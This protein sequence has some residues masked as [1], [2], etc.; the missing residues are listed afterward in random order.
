MKRI[1]VT[2]T[3]FLVLAFAGALLCGSA[4]A[5]EKKVV[6]RKVI[7]AEPAD[8]EPGNP[9]AENV[10]AK[11]KALVIEAIEPG[12]EAMRHRQVSWLGVST[13]ETTDALTSQLGLSPGEGLVVSY[14][15]EDSPAAKAGLKQND[16]LVQF[17]DQSLVHPAQLKKLVQMRKEGESVDITY[18]RAGKKDSVSVTLGKHAAEPDSFPELRVLQGNMRDLQ[19]H[20]REL[21]IREQLQSEMKNLRESLARS[22]ID[23]ERLSSEIKRSVEQARRQAEQ[24]LRQATNAR[25]ALGPAARQLRDL[26]RRSVDVE[27]NATVTI[28]SEGNSVKTVVKTD[29]TGTYVIVANPKKRLTAHDKDGKLLFDGQVDTPEQQEKVPREVWEKVEPLLDKLNAESP[30]EP[31][32]DEDDSAE[33]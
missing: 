15:A 12:A 14:V 8:S 2:G 22:G 31:K 32:F 17:G 30:E 1:T 19:Q 13:E 33:G 21:P 9:G 16:V 6:E 4:V 20:L 11:H 28:K 27:K 26:A 24:A 10:A 23:K 5:A 3:E 7:V 25:G 29:D 18:F